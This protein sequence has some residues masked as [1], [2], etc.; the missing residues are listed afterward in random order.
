M[1]SSIQILAPAR[2]TPK[3]LKF[4]EGYVVAKVANL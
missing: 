4:R 2:K 3:A 1:F